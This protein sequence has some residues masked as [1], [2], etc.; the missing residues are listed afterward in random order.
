MTYVNDLTT[1]QQQRYYSLISTY[2]DRQAI[3]IV[4]GLTNRGKNSY[5]TF[6]DKMEAVVKA[7]HDEQDYYTAL[8]EAF[9]L[10]KQVTLGDVIR[11]VGKVRRNLELDPYKTKLKIRSEADFFG[12]FVFEEVY[13]IETDSDSNETKTLIGYNPI[14]RVRPEVSDEVD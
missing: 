12:L 14:A 13:K 2:G 6:I 10:N 9:E 1:T 3:E 7:K 11:I 8:Y 4:Q 5:T